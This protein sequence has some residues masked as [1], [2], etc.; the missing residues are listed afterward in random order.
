MPPL[1][2]HLAVVVI[3]LLLDHIFRDP[4]RILGIPHPVIIMGKCITTVERLVYPHATTKQWQLFFGLLAVVLVLCLVAVP[5]GV[6]EYTLTLYWDFNFIGVCIAAWLIAARGLFD[7]VLAVQK[8]CAHGNLDAARKGLYSLAGRNTAEL[9][10]ADIL[11]TGGESLAENF[12]DAV[13]APL[14]YYVLFGLPGIVV[15]K[16]INTLD[17]M[18]GY[19]NPRFLYFG[20]CAARLDDLANYLPARLAAGLLLLA[21]LS[22][23]NACVRDGGRVLWRDAGKHPSPNAGYP[24]SAMA[25]LAGLRF[26]G[27]RQYPG[28]V[29]E[30]VWLGDGRTDWCADDLAFCL[31]LYRRAIVLLAA[32]S[33]LAA[34]LLWYIQ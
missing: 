26:G 4:E 21:G 12:S 11:R 10:A 19:R 32:L 8:D 34:G 7:H 2:I 16:T 5:A 15:Y 3:I 30:D 22:K 17:S 9:S 25:G 33:T 27:P 20:R 1:S 23:K 31:G 18:W 24:E 6:L 14:F 29:T 13:V 28:G